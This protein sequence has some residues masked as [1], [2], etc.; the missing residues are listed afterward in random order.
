MGIVGS[1]YQIIERI[2]A[3]GGGNVYLAEHLRL[4]KKVVLKAD[5]RKLSTPP[6]LL[7]R[8]VDVL[9]NL[10]HPY[11]PQVYDFFVENGTVY[12]VMDYIQGESLDRPLKRGEVFSQ[13]QVIKWA[14]QLLDALIYLH[15]PIHGEPPKGFI[16]SDIKPANLMRQQDGSICLIDFNIALALGEESAIGCSAGYAS[17][18]HY[19]L[20]YTT[21]VPT[22]IA[23]PKRPVQDPDATDLATDIDATVLDN[24][25]NLNSVSYGKNA[26]SFTK[27][28][29]ILPDVRSD[30]YS[31]GATLYHLLTGQ[32]PARDA[33]QV[34][35]ISQAG[36][37]PLVAAIIAKA[38]EPNPNLRYQSAAEMQQAFFQLWSDDPRV[39][40]MKHSRAAATVIF[41]AAM[42]ASVFA[43]FV[44]LKRMQTTERYLKLAEYSESE[45]RQ[46]NVDKALSFAL[47]AFPDKKTIFTPQ[48]VSQAQNAL[49]KALG[50][51]DLADG[52][53]AYGTI[54]LA[55]APIDVR[56][57]PGGKTAVVLISG[58][59]ELLDVAG[60][61]ILTEWETDTSA[62]SEA[63]YVDDD[64]LVYA[65]NGGI[66][67]R[68]IAS[69]EV[70][71][72]GKPATGITISADGSKAAG[73]Y[74]DAGEA[75]IYDIATGY[76]QR[77][78]WG[79][80]KQQLTTNDRFANPRDNLFALNENG[81]LLAASFADGTIELFNTA[82]GESMQVLAKSEYTHFEGGFYKKYFAFSASNER[83]S[84]FICVDTDTM[85]KT[86]EFTSQYAFSVQTD[87][88]G[89]YLQTENLLV[90]IDPATG[91][92]QPLVTTPKNIL[93]FT[94]EGGQ[95]VTAT[96][97]T[98]DFYNS[99][100][101]QQTS[102]SKQEAL[103]FLQ[104][105]GGI[106]LAAGRDTPSIRLLQYQQHEDLLL[107]SYDADYTHDEARISADGERFMLFSYE[108]FR[109][110]DKEGNLI[111]DKEIPNAEQVYDQQFRREEQDSYLEV[112]YYDGSIVCY[113]AKDGSELRCTQG[114]VPSTELGESFE[115]DDFII[116]APL[117]GQP[118]VY[119]K[120]NHKEVARL[121][122]EDY[123]TYVTQA[124]DEIVVQ[125]TTQ[126][127]YFY[128][129]LLD[130]QC[131]VTAQLPYLSDVIGE[132]LIFD[133]PSGDMRRTRIEH[134]DEL[135]QMAK[136][137]EGT[138]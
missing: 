38:M 70:L 26:N 3:G 100:A 113:D 60:K 81:T 117:H 22:H 124:G 122:K 25:V 110:Y 91:E 132:E 128:G 98:L 88:Q 45:L 16:H 57:S 109:I 2:G 82:S 133:Y 68:S 105:A 92:Q 120:K 69:G 129:E 65:A 33:R 127:G 55:S 46:G 119:N 106:A 56:L 37:S 6:E 79:D 47:E 21:E 130:R 87:E 85:Q 114:E 90:Q 73:V 115:T 108:K 50:V 83:D 8:E 51:Y 11:I 102:V 64:T 72:Q 135:I 101:V 86:G 77:I 107:L 27:S 13:P 42:C 94:H 49:T 126:D 41:T 35:P 34:Q 32:K 44:G 131:R 121:E 52:Y 20:D 104:L 75:Y 7:R 116:E 30:I 97:D 18:E 78:G 89:V 62:L 112:S 58:K 36:V 40:R 111:A 118:I 63:E 125:Y 53:E 48:P 76:A 54:E 103:D 24:G 15:S 1:T 136:N 123:L 14:F 80:K 74:K 66:C 137:K 61:T 71:W 10:H 43:S 59:L 23:T 99:Q 9:K 19:G 28:K 12:T 138:A 39:K 95:T 93:A 134:I 67:A 96:A 5:K 29:I 31:V 4:H 84:V 17:P